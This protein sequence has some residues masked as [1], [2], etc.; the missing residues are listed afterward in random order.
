MADLPLWVRYGIPGLFFAISLV[1]YFSGYIWPWGLGVAVVTL[2][3][4]LALP[5]DIDASV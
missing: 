3:I 2:V 1:I 4:A 5:R